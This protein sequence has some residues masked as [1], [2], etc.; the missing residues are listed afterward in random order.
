MLETEQKSTQ[1]EKNA[2]YLCGCEENHIIQDHVRYG[3]KKNVMKCRECYF[4]YLW[5]KGDLEEIAG[6]YKEGFRNLPREKMGMAKHDPE[7]QFRSRLG[8]AERRLERV[9]HYINDQSNVLEIGSGAGS[10]IS[11]I[12]PLVRSCMA[13]E[14]DPIF[15]GHVRKKCDV[16]VYEEPVENL[17]LSPFDVICMWHVLEH[18]YDPS[19]MIQKLMSMLT[20][21]GVLFIEVPNVLDPLLT[22]YRIPE[23]KEFYYQSP[24]LYCFSPET[25]KKTLEKGGYRAEIFPIQIYGLRNHLRWLIKRKPQSHQ[26][27]KVSLLNIFDRTYKGILQKTQKTDTLFA[28]V[29]KT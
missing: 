11:V 9:E 16:Q 12:K 24:H 3:I 7:D 8:Q 6:F 20:E 5:P 29:R 17:N 1:L 10:F 21:N 2:C 13:I 22:V 23:F 28:I 25:L 18:L 14:L 4:V 15:A 26:E 19:A 27:Q